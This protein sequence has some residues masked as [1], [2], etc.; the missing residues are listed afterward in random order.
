MNDLDAAS[1]APR[2]IPGSWSVLTPRLEL[3]F[4]PD[5]P[6]AIHGWIIPRFDEQVGAPLPFSVDL[7]VLEQ[8]RA[9]VEDV[10]HPTPLSNSVPEQAMR[11]FGRN[12]WDAVAGYCRSEWFA[13]VR[14]F[15]AGRLDIR[16]TDESDSRFHAVPWELMIPSPPHDRYLHRFRISVVRRP[17]Y[18]ATPAVDN[19]SVG[20][21]RV[22][23]VA[24]VHDLGLAELITYLTRESVDHSIC[25]PPTL[26]TVVAMLGEARA[27]GR[28][29]HAVHLHCHGERTPDTEEAY[30]QLYTSIGTET[31]VLAHELGSAL[32][33]E[34]V[35]LVI[36]TACR[37]GTMLKIQTAV[38]M[39][40]LRRGVACVVAMGYYALFSMM[41]V[42]LRQVYSSL[43][44]NGHVVDA[45]IDGRIALEENP[46]R[47]DAKRSLV[48]QDWFVPQVYS[49]RGD[50]ALPVGNASLN[51]SFEGRTY[52]RLA[53]VVAAVLPL[54][55]TLAGIHFWDQGIGHFRAS[56]LSAELQ[57]VFRAHHWVSYTP[58]DYNP[59]TGVAV[60]RGSILSDLRAIKRAGFDGILTF[61]SLAGLRPV[62]ELARALSI[63]VIA[64]VWDPR[65][66][67]E[68]CS[69]VSAAE[70]VRAYVV[71]HN[72]LDTRY[73]LDE[74]VAAISK[75]RGRTGK[76][77]STTEEARYYFE[78]D[79]VT[80]IG[81][82]LMP[83]SHLSL[84][85]SPVSSPVVDVERDVDRFYA[86]GAEL[87]RRA[88]ERARPLLLKV[89]AYPHA[90][91]AS[92]SESAQAAFFLALL[93]RWQDPASRFAIKPALAFHSAFD[94]PWKKGPDFEPWDPSTGLI[95]RD[96]SPRP[97]SDVIRTTW[98]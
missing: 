23:V 64:G 54:L 51:D 12:L 27:A 66:E 74:L 60:S 36:L 65:N 18:I 88:S 5:S 80:G 63:E 32:S 86:V 33:T 7:S 67:E 46:E 72:G 84:R 49:C 87:A 56:R 98:P 71:G 25:S 97:A 75:L 91:A 19:A 83:D 14:R 22:L 31:P 10:P 58:S 73:S 53:R 20:R 6:G 76:P 96:G 8:I 50:V 45:I 81:D 52:P 90:G 4:F 1:T 85:A 48:L 26:A 39:E 94:A 37:S 69:A 21:L 70:C 3:C 38:S 82:F 93:R 57:T 24:A 44:S 43:L 59:Q 29:Y 28:P 2:A 30:L 79:R 41:R 35:P 47:G 78:A 13:A 62:P 42:F 77:V 40:L 17:Q 16:T 55:L 89:V 11:R 61:S 15:G 9:Y 95:R 92:T 34:A 68:L